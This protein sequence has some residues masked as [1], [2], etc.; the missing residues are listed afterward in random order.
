MTVL[1]LLNG[2][3]NLTVYM[4]LK[5]ALNLTIYVTERCTT[6][7]CIYVV[8]SCTKSIYVV[9]GCTMSDSMLLKGAL[10]IFVLLEG[11]LNLTV[12]VLLIGA[13]NLTR[14]AYKRSLRAQEAADATERDVADSERQCKRTETLVNRTATQFSKSEAENKDALDKLSEKLKELEI[15][16]PGLNELVSVVERSKHFLIQCLSEK[17]KKAHLTYTSDYFYVG[18][19]GLPYIIFSQDM[20][21]FWPKNFHMGRYFKFLEMSGFFTSFHLLKRLHILVVLKFKQY[22]L[23]FKETDNYN[24]K[25]SLPEPK[26]N[27]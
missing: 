11:A 27:T 10:N 21:S 2:P 17:C 16:I 8:E 1:M 7:D 20:S 25:L 22:F 12:F 9:E 5:G 18:I 4:L 14:E 13:L 19:L 24:I 15:Q 6:S 3:L 26:N 23:L